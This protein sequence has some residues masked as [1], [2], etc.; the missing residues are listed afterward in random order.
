MYHSLDVTFLEHIPYFSS[1]HVFAPPIDDT[2]FDFLLPQELEPLVIV[3]TES[4]V[5]PR[6]QVYVLQFHSYPPVDVPFTSGYASNISPFIEHIDALAVS[7]DDIAGS[8]P[9]TLLDETLTVEDDDLG[10]R[11]PQSDRR[12]VVH[13]GWITRTLCLISSYVSYSDLSPTFRAYSVTL[14]DTP[15]PRS[16]LEALQEPQWVFAMQ[17]EIGAL[18]HNHTWDPVYLPSR[19]KPVDCR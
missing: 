5:S 19:V 11:Y 12:P 7:T 13:Y 18:Q 1:S 15:I 3:T 9:V 2:P 14:S 8:E 10:C 6:L 4:L 16:V 17:I